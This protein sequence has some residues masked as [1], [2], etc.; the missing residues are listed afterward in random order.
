[1]ATET[2]KRITDIGP[3]YYEKFLPPIIKKNYGKWKYHEVLKPGVLM[4]VGESGDKLYSVR[5]AAPRLTST[6]TIRLFAEIADQF[7]GGYLPPRGER[8]LRRGEGRDG[9]TLPALREDVPPRKVAHRL[10]LLPQHVR[11]GT[12]LGHRHPRRPQDPAEDQHPVAAE[13]LRDPDHGVLVPDGRHS[14]EDGRREADRRNHRGAMHVLRQL[15]HG[16]P[17]D[18][19]RG[20]RERRPLDLGRRQGEQRP[21]RTHVLEAGHPVHPEQPAALA[22]GGGGGEGDRGGVRQE[23][24]QVRAYG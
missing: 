13:D 15:L 18:D 7:S 19:A 6:K 14:P 2:G 11:R 1:M 21:P 8:R 24:L 5:A 9:R 23:R 3:P 4:H 12:L 17:R 10:R 16:V 20:R 22:R